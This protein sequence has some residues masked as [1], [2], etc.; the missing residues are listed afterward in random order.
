ME[1]ILKWVTLT[2]GVRDN[3]R[4]E[5]GGDKLER[6][7]SSEDDIDELGVRDIARQGLGEELRCEVE[8]E[9]KQERRSI[10][11]VEDRKLTWIEPALYR[12]F[13][14]VR[15]K[16][17]EQLKL[18]LAVKARAG[19]RASTKYRGFR[20]GG[21]ITTT[22]ALTP[23]SLP[24]TFG[25]RWRGGP[26]V[27]CEIIVSHPLDEE[28]GVVGIVDEFAFSWGTMYVAG[29]GSPKAATADRSSAVLR[30]ERS[31]KNGKSDSFGE[32]RSIRASRRDVV[33]KQETNRQGHFTATSSIGHKTTHRL[34][35]LLRVTCSALSPSHRRC[36]SRTLA[37]LALTDSEFPA[38]WMGPDL[39]GKNK[40][41][42]NILVRIRDIQSLIERAHERIGHDED[43][44]DALTVEVERIAV[45]YSA[46][47]G[48]SVDKETGGKLETGTGC[49]DAR[50]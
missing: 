31:G 13:Q 35:K 9:G 37:A 44:E 24:G 39:V 40:E 4:E 41:R 12:S 26:R 11:T 34:C 3:A 21:I 46:V 50:S 30:V 27:V 15:T 20:G 25:Q 22:V 7:M 1:T 42:N 23:K 48:L 17:L 10:K 8:Y 45:M 29:R 47:F 6:G 43:P 14:I 28:G 5:L 2:A 49:H 36:T 38:K 16:A 18:R 33:V 19:L 32:V